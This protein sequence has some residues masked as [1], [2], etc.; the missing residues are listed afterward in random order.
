MALLEDV[1]SLIISLTTESSSIIFI[2]DIPDNVNSLSLFLTGGINTVYDIGNKST[3]LSSPT[4]QIIIKDSSYS[5]CNTRMENI[6]TKLDGYSGTMSTKY[7]TIFKQGDIFDLGKDKHNKS[8][9]SLNFVCK[10]TY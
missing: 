5:T 3:I 2:G 8:I 7:I 6:R 9:L 1:R 4:F 10:I